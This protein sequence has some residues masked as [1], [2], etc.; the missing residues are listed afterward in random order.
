MLESF[1]AALRVVLPMAL[2]MALGAGVRAAG[3]ID[4]T[5]M[6]S[7]DK[8]TFRLFMPVLLFKN[9]YET[10]L[11]Q[12]F[13]P[14]EVLFAAL[15][16]LAMFPVALLLPARLERDR[17]KAASIGQ[18]MMRTNYILFGIAVAESLYGE[19][20]IGPV[21]LLG[22]FVVPMTNALSVVILEVNRSGRT[23]PQQ[24]A[25]AI[26]KNPMVLATLTML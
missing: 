10:D 20:N 25:L 14:E 13:E 17:N 26:L 23:S 19:G 12:S 15:A 3:V 24:L 8:L 21:A 16:L 2:L 18:A 7:V 5:A 1:L 11:A 6:R 9:I 4:R 22:A